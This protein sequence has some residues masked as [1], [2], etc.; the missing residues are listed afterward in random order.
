[1]SPLLCYGL[2]IWFVVINLIGFALMG[3][4]KRRAIRNQ[5]RISEK[6]L[7][8]SA[9]LGGSIGATLG[10][11]QFRHKTKHWYF[12]WGLPALIALQTTLG[13]WAYWFFWI[14]K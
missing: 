9:L 10:M 1:M 13:I 11:R 5:W 8:L 12:W 2:L 3:I 6:H 14:P 7:F 4:D